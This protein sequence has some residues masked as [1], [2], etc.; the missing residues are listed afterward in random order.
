MTVKGFASIASVGGCICV[1]RQGSVVK[2][3][4]DWNCV[5]AV[6]N[7][8]PEAPDLQ[9]LVELHRER[10]IEVALL[11]A[12]ASENTRSRIF[13]GSARLFEERRS[14]I[15]WDDLPLVLMPAARGLSY[16]DY[17]YIVGDA[18]TFNSDVDALWRVLATRVERNPLRHLPGDL[19]WDDAAIQSTHLSK[20]RNAWCDVMSAY[21]HIRAGRDVFVTLNTKHFQKNSEKLRNIGMRCIAAPERALRIPRY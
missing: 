6:E 8:Q 10:R 13:P 5:I 1:K 15:G 17:S 20:W 16:F 2:F 3:T 12:S 19:R 14:S 18:D 11:A 21:S 7:G 9:A 4:F